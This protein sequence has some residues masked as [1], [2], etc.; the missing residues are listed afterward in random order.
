MHAGC[1]KVAPRPSYSPSGTHMLL[2]CVSC[3]FPIAR[4][5]GEPAEVGTLQEYVA[6]MKPNQPGIFYEEGLDTLPCSKGWELLLWGFQ[7]GS[8]KALT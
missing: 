7:V 3:S 4:R 6:A 2:C 8:A 5:V 1:I